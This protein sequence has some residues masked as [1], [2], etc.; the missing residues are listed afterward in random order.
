MEIDRFLEV[1]DVEITTRSS[2]DGHYPA[3]DTLGYVIRNPM[4]AE[5]DMFDNR[6]WSIRVR[7]FIGSSLVRI[8]RWYQSLKI[9]C[10]LC[11][12]LSPE[13]GQQLFIRPCFTSRQTE[14]AN[15][16]EAY[17]LTFI[18]VLYS[19]QPQVPTSRKRL[20]SSLAQFPVLQFSNLIKRLIGHLHH[21]ES[22]ERSK[23]T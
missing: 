16:F 10:S 22:R 7:F 15:Q 14:R 13:I 4:R 5:H 21:M 23:Y 11:S 12:G 1:F 20:I 17:G 9:S 8:T 2:I 18:V 6:L 19:G 3:D